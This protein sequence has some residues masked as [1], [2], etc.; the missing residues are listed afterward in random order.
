MAKKKNSTST[1]LISY[2]MEYTLEHNAAPKSV[3]IFAKKYN[4]QE[5]IFY[6]YFGNFDALEQTI[7]KTFFDNTITLLEK[8]DDYKSYES[9]NQLLSF[10][11][12]FFELLTANRSYVVYAL[13]DNKNNLTK[14]KSLKGLKHSFTKY[15]ESL[16][17]PLLEIKQETLDKIQNTT[18]KE[19]A[20]LQFSLTMKYWLKD[21]S[22]SFEKTDV[23]IE[24]SVNTSFD[25]LN[26]KPIKSI[27]DLGKFLY[28]DKTFNN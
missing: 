11:Y 20:W 27:I 28:K 7:F 13:E 22:P 12:S 19:T 21:T 16:N 3:Y 23:F 15:V 9:R 10:Y 25:I 8:S 2:Y 18:L 4:F 5:E 24:K 1:D 6:K 26:T 14:S 17:I